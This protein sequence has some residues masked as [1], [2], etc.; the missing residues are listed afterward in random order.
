M[1]RHFHPIAV[2]G[3]ATLLA[4]ALIGCG[5]GSIGD[6]NNRRSG[7]SLNGFVFKGPVSNA[8]VTAY[9]MDDA[10]RRGEAL[11][12]ADTDGNGAFSLSLP[13]YTGHVLL[14]ASSGTYT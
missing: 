13:P 8:R 4:F 5:G 6:L 2:G 9:K 3:S 14:V 11:G 10:F 1:A 12:S 7:S